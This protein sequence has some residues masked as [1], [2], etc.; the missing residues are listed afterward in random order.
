MRRQAVACSSASA[1]GTM[2][3]DWPPSR[4]RIAVITR[5][6]YGPGETVF[7]QEGRPGFYTGSP[8]P[9][10]ERR[11]LL[12]MAHARTMKV[13][14]TSPHRRRYSH[15]PYQGHPSDTNLAPR[16]I[17]KAVVSG[18]NAS[19]PR[20]TPPLTNPCL[21]FDGEARLLPS[22]AGARLGTGWGLAWSPT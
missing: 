15:N 11:A 17:R 2:N 4:V 12:F 18:W 5:L 8:Q 13:Q 14:V 7:K 3:L 20:Q 9:N 10:H 21:S 22:P 19:P 6:H 1:V 16:Q